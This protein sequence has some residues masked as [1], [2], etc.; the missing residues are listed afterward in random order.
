MGI[1]EAAAKM[2]SPTRALG[3]EGAMPSGKARIRLG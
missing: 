1:V 3:S 2:V